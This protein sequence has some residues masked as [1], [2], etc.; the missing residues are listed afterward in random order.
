[1][2]TNKLPPIGLPPCKLVGTDGNVFSI[3]GN[4][5]NALTKVGLRERASEFKARAF[6]SKSYDDVLILCHEFVDVR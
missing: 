5:C 6:A 4:V 1:M 2:A 3:I